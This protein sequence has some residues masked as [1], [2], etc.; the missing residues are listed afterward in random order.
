MSA[1]RFFRKALLGLVVAGWLVPALVGGAS[2]AQSPAP[3]T[4][5]TSFGYVTL[6]SSPG[7]MYALAVDESERIVAAGELDGHWVVTRILANG[8]LDTSFGSAGQVLLFGQTA[9]DRAY[10]VALQSDG[11]IVVVG[12]TGFGVDEQFTVVRL[13]ANGGL[14]ST[15]GNGGIVKTPINKT[16]AIATAVAIQKD[17]KIVVGGVSKNSLA[18]QDI[19]LA[20]YNQDGSLDTAGFGPLVKKNK[21]DRYGYVIDDID[22]ETGDGV[23]RG[24][25]ALQPDGKILVGGWAGQLGSH[26]EQLRGWM[27]ARYQPDGSV[28][29]SFGTQGKVMAESYGPFTYLHL[30]GLAVQNDGKIVAS[31]RGRPDYPATFDAIV[32]RYEANGNLDSGFGSGGLA[33]AGFPTEVHGTQVALQEDGK[34]VVALSDA[35]LMAFRFLADGTP[36]ATFGAGHGIDGQSERVGYP[37]KTHAADAIALSSTGI[38]IGGDSYD[39]M[40]MTLTKFHGNETCSTPPAAPTALVAQAISSSRIDLAWT[41]NAGDEQGFKIERSLDG[42]SFAPIAV[43][44]A[45]VTAYQDTGLASSTTYYYQVRAYNAAGDSAY[46]NVASDTTQTSVVVDYLATGDIPVAGQVSGTFADTQA[47]DDTYQAIQ[48]IESGGKPS[49]RYSYLEHRWTFQVSSGA[50]FQLH[51]QAYRTDSGEGDAFTF[52]VSTDGSSF[53]DVGTVTRTADDGQYQVFTLPAGLSGTVYVRVRDADRTPGRR[54]LDTV[55]VDHLFIRAE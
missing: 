33:C 14:D 36:D 34:I 2:D 38:F 40:V 46:T 23:Y 37:G 1:C 10:D 54:T 29:D 13:D 45:D 9:G 30:K 27:V 31:G 24:V 51:V 20:R 21:P 8:T 4:M 3:G 25:I 44:G 52:A 49:N 26:P 41:D 43:V 6:L 12:W 15:F 7:R 11:K 5:D 35:D 47:A 16:G 17:G 39:P 22:A 53:V 32:L 50:T 42:S 48:E 55:F 28:D 18:R 19:T